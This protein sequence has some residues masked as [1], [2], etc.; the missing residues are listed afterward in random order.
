MPILEV[1]RLKKCFGA[2]EV[3]RDIDFSLEQGET[4]AVIGSSGSGKTT[5][6]RCL[7]FLETPDG[8]QLLVG[9]NVIFDA[10]DPRPSGR[11]RGAENACTLDLVFQ[12]FKSV[13]PNIRS[14]RTSSSR[15]SFWRRNSPI[16]CR[17]GRP[18]SPKS[19]AAPA[20]CSRRWGSP[21][22]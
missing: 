9:G 21:T 1:K 7:N 14:C 11:A 6:L 20:R 5:L 4:I 13:P 18:S 10:S 8:G 17:T 12:S 16:T 2:L 19:R 22:S 15:R 3:L